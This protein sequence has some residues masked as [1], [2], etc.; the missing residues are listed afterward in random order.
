MNVG[1]LVSCRHDKTGKMLG[2]VLHVRKKYINAGP[3]IR[4][5]VHW[6]NPADDEGVE[7]WVADLEVL[8]EA[9]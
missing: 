9:R 4:A 1:D 6:S 3:P 7:D 2:I 5:I 8:S